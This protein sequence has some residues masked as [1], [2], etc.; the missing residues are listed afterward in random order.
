MARLTGGDRSR[1]LLEAVDFR[2]THK[3][4]YTLFTSSLCLQC[5]DGGAT[6]TWR[7]VGVA[8]AAVTY[9]WREYKEYCLL[10]WG[11]RNQ[12]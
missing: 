4:K 3:M 10:L 5:C 2:K 1:T 9:F 11:S 7:G 6:C 8:A 12:K